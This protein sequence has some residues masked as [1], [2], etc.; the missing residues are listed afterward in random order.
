[1]TTELP[2]LRQNAV[3]L[4]RHQLHSRQQDALLSAIKVI[5]SYAQEANKKEND[6]DKAI[7]PDLQVG[8]LA[9]VLFI[10]GARGSGKSSILLSLIQSTYMDRKQSDKGRNWFLEDSRILKE[11]EKEK[12]S[13]KRKN[14]ESFIQ[15]LQDQ[16]DV[17]WLKPLDLE[18]LPDESNLLAAILVRLEDVFKQ[19]TPDK[20]QGTHEYLLYPKNDKSPL[21]RFNKL[22]ND[23]S[24]G[25]DSQLMSRR[26]SD[27]DSYSQELRRT[28]Q[29]RFNIR[30]FNQILGDMAKFYKAQS[31][32]HKMPLFI[33][34][35]DDADLNPTRYA[36]LF[37]LIRMLP[38]RN[39]FF[40][41]SGNYDNF[42]DLFE[43]GFLS[44]F[45]KLTQGFGANK[46][47]PHHRVMAL[48]SQLGYAARRKN[49]PGGVHHVQVEPFTV[50]EAANFRPYNLLGNTPESNL[51]LKWLLCQ[52]T[53]PRD[54]T[55]NKHLYRDYVNPAQN[56]WELMTL[57]K[58]ANPNSPE[59]IESS[60]YW[61]QT[62]YLMA[63]PPRAVFDLWLD[64]YQLY[65]QYFKGKNP[66]EYDEQQLD[67]II[68]FVDF[69]YQEC[70]DSEPGL[71][72]NVKE[73]LR[74][75]FRA[76]G[77]RP[78]YE[79]TNQ[80]VKIEA[81]GVARVYEWEQ[82]QPPL[83]QQ[84][85]LSK[86]KVSKVNIFSISFDDKESNKRFFVDDF[87]A[88]WAFLLHDLM[89]LKP[90]NT[91]E[92]LDLSETCLGLVSSSAL[93]RTEFPFDWPTPDWLTFFELFSFTCNWNREID[94]RITKHPDLD[95]KTI[96]KIWIFLINSITLTRTI[97]WKENEGIVTNFDNYLLNSEPNDEITIY[98][99]LKSATENNFDG[100][101]KKLTAKTT[102]SILT[103]CSPEFGL[104]YQSFTKP[105]IDAFVHRPQTD[106]TSLSISDEDIITIAE[107]RFK[108]IYR[109]N[110]S[111]DP[112]GSNFLDQHIYESG[113]LNNNL[114]LS[115]ILAR[116]SDNNSQEGEK[117]NSGNT[118]N[119]KIDGIVPVHFVFRPTTF[120]ARMKK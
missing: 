82:R 97:E 107:K 93:S 73:Q 7:H 57:Q 28:E 22:M 117:R 19:V 52:I 55:N 101:R 65:E 37:K 77:K 76:T 43:F 9:N 11:E 103:L 90:G 110:R 30:N 63:G 6:D 118:L 53:L 35:V 62:A 24:L 67:A 13:Q 60:R 54:T 87:R 16:T 51:T 64:V 112:T 74:S 50:W 106:I 14:F 102:V 46:D 3:P 98:N 81:M 5:C 2:T 8:K 61:P 36:E 109:F 45:Q 86:F 91:I 25:W 89:L 26:A 49:L 68:R 20:S 69:T 78:M 96:F 42:K 38:A 84:L 115:S 114:K 31:E 17:Q 94:N 113:C 48:A 47:Y 66:D 39:L 80:Q 40:V 72:Y 99:D 104:D 75:L 27:P 23:V 33:L 71:P 4:K 21:E 58:G 111:I 105:V 34:P 12:E 92:R 56:L 18:L 59:T 1:M 79:H 70:I 120:L 119:L 85:F 88:S 44:D 15:L 32:H 10:D 116:G 95:I 83:D 100:Y 41:I 29:A 108:I